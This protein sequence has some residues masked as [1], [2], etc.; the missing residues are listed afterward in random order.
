MLGSKWLGAAL[1]WFALAAPGATAQE[2]ARTEA[3]DA[4]TVDLISSL[5]VQHRGR[6]KP[7]ESL[8]GLNLLMI[9]GKRSL[10]IE[11]G[12]KLKPSDWL[13]D[14][15]FFPE[16]A[17]AYKSF[18]IE[19]DGVLTAIGLDGRKKRDWYS[20]NELEPAKAKLGAAASRAREKE[21]SQQSV[22]ERQLVKLYHDLFGFESLVGFL[23]PLRREY[24]VGDSAGLAEIFGE[25]DSVGL[26]AL[27]SA[28]PELRQLASGIDPE[29]E[30][31]RDA[32]N[33]L[34]ME[35]D[36][37]VGTASMGPAIFPPHAEADDP[38]EW[39]TIGDLVVSS[40]SSNADFSL[41]LRLLGEWE[42]LAASV[43]DR[44]A[45]RGTLSELHGDLVEQASVRGEYEHIPLE[46]KLNRWK[47]FTN[48]L[49][50]YLL[51][52]LLLAGTW[53]A[54]KAKLL[55]A[56]VWGSV[57]LATALVIFGIV[58][59]CIIRQRPPVVTL[60][61]TILFITA[62]IVLVALGM[63]WMTRQRIG[64]GVAVVLGVFGM[65]LAGRY[66]LKEVASAGDTMASVVAVLDTNYYLAI[67]VTT[68]TIGY[69]GGL[70]AA[71]IAHVW[72]LGQLF[73]FR[74]GDKTWYKSVT[75]MVY[76]VICFCLL[77]SIFGTIMGG[78]WANDSWGRFW[79]WDPKENGALL[80]CIWQLLALHLRMGGY[81]R[82][83]GLAV[84]AIL[85]GVVVS[86]SWWGVNLLNVGLHSYGFT[87]G[88]AT[89]LAASWALELLVLLLSG[90]DYFRRGGGTP[91]AAN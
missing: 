13:L 29:D 56:G 3:W 63:E 86:F 81:I 32:I 23:D 19:N 40:F 75:R 34:L 60:Y 77:F 18:R 26:T 53:L 9:N 65:F 59:R 49:V 31:E 5:P 6:V 44:D 33:R 47:L 45:F 85:G 20:Y 10:E 76:G 88:V 1:V 72:I 69:A 55:R 82:D 58:V 14:C 35:L 39:W 66:E 2:V 79:G 28:L 83:R 84:M 16:Q 73:G 68:I 89:L 48:A 57:S 27:T 8:A 46:V 37:L 70:L 4:E 74:R 78:V 17:K 21:P 12:E 50:F 71:G 91:L 62:V 11:G 87:S 24:E 42:R 15:F 67:H 54:P 30:S 90:I 36:A 61:D 43:D 52:F 22:V 41:Q 7:L 64:I 51:A 80:I 25:V 38:L